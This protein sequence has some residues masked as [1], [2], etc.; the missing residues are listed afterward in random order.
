M[1]GEYKVLLYHQ[2]CIWW[3]VRVSKEASLWWKPERAIP[4]SSFGKSKR[5]SC[6]KTEAKCSMAH[7]FSLLSFLQQFSELKKATAPTINTYRSLFQPLPSANEGYELSLFF[8]LVNIP[9]LLHNAKLL[10]KANILPACNIRKSLKHKGVKTF[11]I[12]TNVL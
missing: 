2:K 4:Q 8:V 1:V 3:A 5:D 11:S 6:A 7:L 9:G 10:G 12:L